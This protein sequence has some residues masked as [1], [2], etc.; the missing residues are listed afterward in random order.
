MNRLKGMLKDNPTVNGC[1]I[2]EAT[3]ETKA[4]DDEVIPALGQP[5]Q[6]AGRHR[7]A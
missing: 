3:A 6:P 5:L 4:R 2:T 7:G 1:S